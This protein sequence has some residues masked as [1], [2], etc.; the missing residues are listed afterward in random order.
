[1]AAAL[2]AFWFAATMGAAMV[3][4]ALP[5]AVLLVLPMSAG[6][7]PVTGALVAFTLGALVLV[8]TLYA[9]FGITRMMRHRRV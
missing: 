4:G 6:M 7:T 5:A 2:L 8:A 9:G 1:M 3:L